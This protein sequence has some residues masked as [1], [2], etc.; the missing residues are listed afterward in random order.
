MAAGAVA[1]PPHVADASHERC[2]EL[3]C[4]DVCAFS[5]VLKLPHGHSEACRHAG[6]WRLTLEILRMMKG[7]ANCVSYSSALAAT[8]EVGEDVR[9]AHA[10]RLV[11]GMWP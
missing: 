10:A 11:A 3:Q 6:Q 5:Y 2:P 9:Q 7:M 4:G 1:L 8:E